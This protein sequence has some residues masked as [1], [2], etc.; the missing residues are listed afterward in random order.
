VLG[1]FHEIVIVDSSSTDGTQKLAEGAGIKIIDFK[2]TGGF[3]KKR[4]WVLLNFSFGTPWVLFLDADEHVTESCRRELAE[5][6]GTSG[7]VGYWLNYTIHFSG[8]RLRYGLGQR[9]LALFRVGA[10]LYERI[11][12]TG[13]SDLDMEVHEHPILDG[14]VG[15]ISAP[16]EHS[17]YN[18]VHRFVQRHNDYASW[19]ANRYLALTKQSAGDLTRRQTLK[20]QYIERWWYPLGY[21]LLTYVL[22]GGFLDGR[23]GFV[24]AMMKFSYLL[25]I[26]EK[27]DEAR[28]ARS[29]RSADNM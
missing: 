28:S 20:Y 4:N 3:P 8:K 2:W 24:Y 7:Y 15:Q 26:R 27:I 19:E 23:A 14:K 5:K 9:K 6:I 1:F 18:G 22:K 11:D 29:T 10:G 17:D 13:W 21:F 12:D 16:I 25:Q